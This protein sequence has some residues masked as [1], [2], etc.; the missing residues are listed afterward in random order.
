[1]KEYKVISGPQSQ[2]FETQINAAAEEGYEP[3]GGIAAVDGGLYTL[4][5]SRK[6][7]APVKKKKAGGKSD[8][9][10]HGGL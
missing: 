7:Q 6:K 1:M 4:L 2:A 10:L 9:W 5:M 8:D 3:E